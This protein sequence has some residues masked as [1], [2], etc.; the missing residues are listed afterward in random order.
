MKIFLLLFLISLL[1]PEKVFINP[2]PRPKGQRVYYS[3][4][5]TGDRYDVTR[6]YDMMWS[7]ASEYAPGQIV[8]VANYAGRTETYS[9]Q[10]KETKIKRDDRKFI[11]P[12]AT[13]EILQKIN[14]QGGEE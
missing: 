10:T 14:N 5:P 9:P 11:P 1:L 4:Y 6:G 7:Q 3:P 2:T 8:I 12:Y 13:L